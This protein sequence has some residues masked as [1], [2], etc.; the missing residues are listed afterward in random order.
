M[1][2]QHEGFWFC[3]DTP[4]DH[5][6]LSEMWATGKAPWTVWKGSTEV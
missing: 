3:V 4:R 1:A 6:Q 5:L 2:Y